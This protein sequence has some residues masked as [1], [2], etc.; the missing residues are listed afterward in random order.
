MLTLGTIDYLNTQPVERG[1]SVHLPDIEIIR[2]VP[3]AINRALLEGR[4]AA[5]PISAYE[6]ARHTDDLLLIPDLSIAT[7]GA[8]NSVLLFSWHADPRELDGLPVALTD[9][10]ATSINLLRVL[11][12]RHYDIAP[13]W[14]TMSQDLDAMLGA[15][16]GALVIGDRALV[17][18]VVRRHVGRRGLPYLFDLGD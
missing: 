16:A 11:C 4:V 7:L 17:E 18:G 1:V 8:V 5:G 9:H 14:R 13:E 2:G 12:E 6:F 15:C 3:T 10:S